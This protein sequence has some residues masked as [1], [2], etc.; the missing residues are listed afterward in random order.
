MARPRVFVSSTF[1]DLKHVRASLELF[2]ESLGF[3]AILFEKGDIT[4]HPDFAL[5]ESCYREAEGSDIF[6]LI[7]GGRYGSGASDTKLQDKPKFFDSYRSITEK[8]F[9]TAQAADIPTF[10]M[11]DKAVHAEYQTYTKNKDNQSI[12]YA[13]VDSINVFK[14]IDNI[15][16]KNKNNPVHNFER[17]SDM[18]SWLREQWSGLFRELLRTRSQQKQ[19]SALNAQVS[20]LQS[21]NETLK[22]YLEAVLDKISPESDS[23][24]KNEHEKL[25][26][27]KMNSRLVNNQFY[28]Y[29]VDSM[30]ID[31]GSA[32]EI[33]ANPTNEEEAIKLI[34]SKIDLID[35]KQTNPLL[36][37]P[38]SIQYY[39]RARS[40]MGKSPISFRGDQ[41]YM[42]L[43]SDKTRYP[44]RA[45]ARRS[46]EP[47]K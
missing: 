41:L 43:T 27:E 33:I 45:K 46:T 18:E 38:G 32:R 3:D 24:I 42:N 19:L 30:G 17:A 9:D 15:F 28:S 12:N 29:L 40:I 7:I 11:L 4:F 36:E 23:L 31:D 34:Q 1:Y 6:V 14:L 37:F 25:E 5:D 20:Q 10:I 8:E 35:P 21:I 44:T 16:A 2:I 22:N 13:H 47:D 39:N 26:N